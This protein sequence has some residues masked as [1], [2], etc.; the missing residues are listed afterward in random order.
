MNFDLKLSISLTL[1]SSFQSPRYHCMYSEN[2]PENERQSDDEDRF[3]VAAHEFSGKYRM[4]M[5]KY[6]LLLMK[7]SMVSMQS[8]IWI[9]ISL[10][11]ANNF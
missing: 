9:V 1:V 5:N 10:I 11:D 6:Q 7:E 4:M 3:V 8:I 2:D